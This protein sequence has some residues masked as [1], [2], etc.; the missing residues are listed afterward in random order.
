V[1]RLELRLFASIY[2]ARGGNVALAFMAT[3]GLYLDRT[4]LLGAAEIAAERID[5]TSAGAA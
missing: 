1:S 5:L 4:A 3:G 2:G